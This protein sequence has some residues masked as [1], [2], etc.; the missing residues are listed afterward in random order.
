MGVSDLIIPLR[1][2][3]RV[4][5]HP[6]RRTAPAAGRADFALPT[7]TMRKAP[8]C[9]RRCRSA[10]RAQFEMRI[11]P[12]ASARGHFTGRRRAAGTHTAQLRQGT[13]SGWPKSTDE[14]RD[15]ASLRRPATSDRAPQRDAAPAAA[16][17]DAG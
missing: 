16:G 14:A 10:D 12:A 15:R 11:H 9:V 8:A 1:E 7:R 3:L 4:E 5:Y 17:L 2:L 6:R 13:S